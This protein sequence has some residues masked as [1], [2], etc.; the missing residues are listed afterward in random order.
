MSPVVGKVTID[1]PVEKVYALLTRLENLTKQIPHD[2]IYGYDLEVEDDI[3]G[4]F[5]L[6]T[7]ISTYHFAHDEDEDDWCIEYEVIG[8]EPNKKIVLKQIY[9]GTYDK[10]EDG[11]SEPIQTEPIFGMIEIEMEFVAIHNR[12]SIIISRTASPT[13]NIFRFV[14]WTSY[15]IER[16]SRK[17]YYREWASLVQQYA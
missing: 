11:W 10:D 12:T 7:I 1:K 2:A 9:L 4:E 16:I 17:K 14:F 3:S 5:K 8:L 15:L 13:K 6:G